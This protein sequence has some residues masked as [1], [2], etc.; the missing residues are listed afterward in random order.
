MG[1]Y[2]AGRYTVLYDGQGTIEYRAA[3]MD[4]VASRQGRGV[5]EL[6]KGYY[7]HPYHRY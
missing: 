4:I 6:E 1:H 7:P 3:Q 5:I 2:P